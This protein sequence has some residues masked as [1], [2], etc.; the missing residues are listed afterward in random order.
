VQTTNRPYNLPEI[1]QKIAST[2]NRNGVAE[3]FDEAAVPKTIA[4]DLSRIPYDDELLKD[5]ELDIL[6]TAKPHDA[7]PLY[8]LQPVAG[9]G[10]ILRLVWLYD[11]HDLR[12]FPSV[13]EFA[14]D[15]RLIKWSQDSAGQRLGTSRHKI[16][17]APLKWAFSE[18][19]SLF[20]RHHPQGQKRLSRLE[21]THDKGK[22]LSM[23]APKRARAVYLRLKRQVA[24]HRDICLQT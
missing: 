9:M 15:C 24:F 5:L 8:R 14:S 16:G 11:I 17:N 12:R 19:A 22:A 3:R 4:V 6:K 2:A 21:T 18:A 23:L 7:H 10:N 20:V 13:P 1:G